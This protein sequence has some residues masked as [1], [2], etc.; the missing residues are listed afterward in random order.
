MMRRFIF[1]LSVVLTAY[2]ST[3]DRFQ[4]WQ[5]DVNNEDLGLGVAHA[6]AN[7]QQEELPATSRR[8]IKDQCS[9]LRRRITRSCSD[10]QDNASI[11][12]SCFSLFFLLLLA[13]DVELNPG[14]TATTAD[15]SSSENSV[16][17]LQILIAR[18]NVHQGDT[19]FSEESRGRQ[20]AFMALTSLAYNQHDM[21]VT[22]WQPE[23]LD[24]ILHICDSQFLDALRRRFIP[25]ALNLSVEQLPTTVHF[26]TS[27]E[28]NIDLPIVARNEISKPIVVMPHMATK[29]NTSEMPIEAPN[30]SDFPIVERK[31][32]SPILAVNSELP[33]VAT[34]AIT[35]KPPTEAN[36]KL[37][38]E[39]FVC[40]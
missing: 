17:E 34:K 11:S 18:G 15:N 10:R 5:E 3:A 29:A 38:M 22:N 8:W 14:P 33:I 23:A 12:V 19:S 16:L 27:N 4:K 35:E 26:A 2:C 36:S 30:N 37:N 32:E 24:E 13:G 40:L 7:N 28:D 21:A 1:I 25:D 20:C 6:F 31:S 9:K 39:H